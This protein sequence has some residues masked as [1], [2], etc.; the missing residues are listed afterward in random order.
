MPPLSDCWWS[1]SSVPR[2]LL[3]PRHHPTLQLLSKKFDGT[4]G[5]RVR[6]Y[7]NSMSANEM[8]WRLLRGVCHSCLELVRGHTIDV[9][10]LYG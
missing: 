10:N 2:P 5:I 6:K 7:K 3:V 1:M 4:H 8:A 9:T